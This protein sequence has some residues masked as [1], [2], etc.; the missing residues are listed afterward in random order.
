M[1]L[2]FEAFLRE[3]AADFRRLA[4]ATRGEMGPDDL[5]GEAY[6][7]AVRLGERLGR[8]LVLSDLDDQEALIAALYVA[9]VR[10]GDWQHRM[11]ARLYSEDDDEDGY[12]PINY[13]AAPETSDPLA[14]LLLEE[15]EQSALAESYSE[16]AA[17]AV[18]F[19]NFG[20][21]SARLC[22]Y[23][24]I[25]DRTLRLWVA[26]AIA[27]VLKQPSIFDRIERIPDDFMPLPG[28]TYG[29]RVEEG[30]GVEQWAWEF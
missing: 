23:L 17:Y 15:G 11:A 13:V 28:K 21:D 27:A 24:V 16:A 25:A 7:M 5:A 1:D 22:A 26:L 4:A 19:S 10:Q 18:M 14:K 20:N 8:D 3:R 29:K 2:F 30:G 12:N 6:L 9:H